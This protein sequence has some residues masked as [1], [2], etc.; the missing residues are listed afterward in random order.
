MVSQVLSVF[1]QIA[2]FHHLEI[3]VNSTYV[4]SGGQWTTSR[5]QLGFFVE[6]NSPEAELTAVLG[7]GRWCPCGQW[8]GWVPAGLSVSSPRVLVEVQRQTPTHKCY[9]SVD[10]LLVAAR[11]SVCQPG[12]GQAGQGPS[13]GDLAET[14]GSHQRLGWVLARNE[15]WKWHINVGETWK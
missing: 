8:P 9:K 11:S 13:T 12:E 10:S 5:M 15:L 3:T 14:P 4:Q 6:M 7:S 1:H 2:G